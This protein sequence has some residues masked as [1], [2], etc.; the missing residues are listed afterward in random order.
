MG[1]N[2][3]QTSKLVISDHKHR[4]TK[5]IRCS[6]SY[7]SVTND[8]QTQWLKTTI[9]YSWLWEVLLWVLPG[10]TGVAVSTEGISLGMGTAGMLGHWASLSISIVLSF[11]FKQVW[12]SQQIR[13]RLSLK[14][15]LH[16]KFPKGGMPHH[17]HEEA[18]ASVRRQMEW[19]GKVGKKLYYGFH[20]KKWVNG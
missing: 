13:R 18:P 9:C 3:S 20:W 19:M 7:C 10:L 6:V 14:R 15:L 16:S 5:D 8:P 17:A 12:W 2:L 11:I 1:S 4:N